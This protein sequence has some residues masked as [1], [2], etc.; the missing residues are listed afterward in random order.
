MIGVPRKGRRTSEPSGP[1]H[2]PGS[3]P[4]ASTTPMARWVIADRIP[5]DFGAVSEP[6]PIPGATQD[7]GSAS[8]RRSRSTSAGRSSRA[9]FQSVSCVTPKYSWTTTFRMA[10]ISGHGRSGLAATT[11]SGTWRAASPMTPKQKRTASTVFSSARNDARSMPAV[12][13]CTRSTVVR[14][15]MRRRHSLGGTDRL[16]KDSRAQLALDRVL[17]DQ[18]DG[19][20]DDGLELSLD[21]EKLEEAYGPVELDQKVHIAVGTRVAA[22]DGTEEIER[23]HAES[24]ELC[25][26]CRE[27]S[28]DFLSPHDSNHRAAKSERPATAPRSSAGL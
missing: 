6:C 11:S 14:T 17:H 8:T 1:A 5:V 21:P 10:R 4:P 27:S 25:P 19:S 13:R 3:R 9:V 24:F 28:L 2:S 7:S 15:S 16:G 22:R 26:M 18:I 23:A 12:Y 20:S